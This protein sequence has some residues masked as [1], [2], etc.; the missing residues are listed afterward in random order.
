MEKKLKIKKYLSYIIYALISG[1]IIASGITLYIAHFDSNILTIDS[2]K[3]IDTLLLFS[4][5][6]ITA[7]PLYVLFALKEK[8]YRCCIPLSLFFF[9]VIILYPSTSVNAYFY[10]ALAIAVI[11][12]TLAFKD[13]LKDRKINFLDGIAFEFKGFKCRGADLFVGGAAVLM[14]AAV[15]FGTVIRMYTFNNSTFDFGLF[16]QMYEYMATDF[17]QNSTLER[18]ELLSHF[19]VH[20]S[21][22][23]YLLLPF[24]MIFRNPQ[25]LLVMQAAVCFSGVFPLLLLCKRWRYGGAVTLALCGVFLCYPALTGACFYDFHENCFLTPFI[26]WILYFLEENKGPGAFV[27]ALLLLCVKEDAGLYLIFI[28]LYSLF[29]KNVK[30]RISIPLLVMGVLGFVAVTAFIDAF[31]EGIKV[32]R[33][34]IYL[35]HGQDSLVSVVKNVIKNPAFFFS[36]LFSAEK[37]LFLLQ[38]LLPLLFIPLRSRKI[39]EW[40]LIAPF[41]LINLATDYKYQYDI[42]FQYVFG[43]GA[44]LIFLTAKNMRYSRQ[45]LRTALAAFMA[46]AVC[47]VGNAMPKYHYT[48]TYYNNT[49]RYE[50]A[51]ELL[52]KIPRDKVIYASTFLTPHL[53][54]CKELYMYPPIYNKEN[55]TDAEY[56][57]IDTRYFGEAELKEEIQKIT[58]NGYVKTDEAAFIIVYQEEMSMK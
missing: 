51:E 28:A 23:Y 24:Y 47:L 14:T 54:D 4:L 50:A 26:L 30:K 57:L 15:S 35:L 11:C 42:N 6:V 1:F 9:S 33:Y 13:V 19:A 2:V 40:F 45:K 31:G 38:M 34:D 16:A 43:T 27:F 12:V 32:S 49:E 22:V 17:T 46:A 7:T 10:I 36:K 58:S 48:D 55:W 20:F 39:S 41:I 8:I 3:E 21:P 37:V 25:S 44:M 29:N 56:I 18:N 52:R 5:T 53:Y